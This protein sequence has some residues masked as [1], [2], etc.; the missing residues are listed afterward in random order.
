MTVGIFEFETYWIISRNQQEEDMRENHPFFD[1]PLFVVGRETKFRKIC[2]AIVSAK[3]NYMTRDPV[4][5]KE[6]HSKYKRFQ[7]GSFY[8]HM[9][10][11]IISTKI[12]S[13]AR[14]RNISKIILDG[15][16]K[17][18][19]SLFLY[20]VEKY[21]TEIYIHFMNIYFQQAA[22]AGDISGLGNDCYHDTVLYIN[23]L[24]KRSESHHV[25]RPP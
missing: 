9:F 14:E 1:T 2:H 12:L 6:L 24:W 4:T 3:Y 18:K 13:M 11:T 20:D 8:I 23:V 15:R 10:L 25:Q 21:W 16:R 7:W 17:L 19:I 5:G 22:W